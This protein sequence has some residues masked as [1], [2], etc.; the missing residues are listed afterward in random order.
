MYGLG[1]ALFYTPSLAILGHYFKRYLGLVNGIVTAGSSIFTV[2]M[3][4]VME[5]LL[6]NFKLAWTLR[7]LALI[8]SFVMIAAF[9]FKPLKKER[10]LSKIDMKSIFNTSLLKNRKY[11]IWIFVIAFSLFGYF[12]PYTYMKDFVQLHYKDTRDGKIPIICV[13]ITSGL[14]RLIAGHIVDRPKINPILL[15]QLAFLVIGVLTMLMTTATNSFTWL[16][17]IS[18]GMGFF[19]GCFVSVLGPIAFDICGPDGA[20]QAIGFLLGVCSIPLTLG[21]YV[22]GIIY[23]SEKSYTIPF[24]LAG[25]PPTIGSVAMFLTRFVRTKPT[26]KTEIYKNGT[27]SNHLN[28]KGRLLHSISTSTLVQLGS[29]GNDQNKRSYSYSV[30]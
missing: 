2:V 12:V 17:L 6:K 15:Q 4:Y 3:P 1:G 9:L 20:A 24:I 27:L 11:L 7:L 22:A 16:V 5:M 25:V 23:D 19:D 13:G 26:N 21:P 10:P 30:Y 18:L 29:N 8:T 28:S 14:G